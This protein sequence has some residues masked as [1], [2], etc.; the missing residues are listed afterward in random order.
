VLL[1]QSTT[2]SHLSLIRESCDRFILALQFI[3]AVKIWSAVGS[4]MAAT[5]SSKVPITQSSL[6]GAVDASPFFSKAL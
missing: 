5:E 3:T 2:E 6:D 1:V 4:L